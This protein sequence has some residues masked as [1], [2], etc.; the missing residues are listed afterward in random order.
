MATRLLISSQLQAPGERGLRLPP[1]S[2]SEG[3]AGCCGLSQS[4]G[5][6]EPTPVQRPML[7]VSRQ[8]GVVVMPMGSTWPLVCLEASKELT[9]WNLR[10]T[11]P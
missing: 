7:P 6:Q 3:A 2:D 10:G 11:V 5:L 9:A 8:G 4:L 1:H